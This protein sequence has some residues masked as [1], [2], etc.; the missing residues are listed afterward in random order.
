M[1]SGL[2]VIERITSL[3]RLLETVQ[4]EAVETLTAALHQGV[5]EAEAADPNDLWNV[6]ARFWPTSGRF[7][8]SDREGHPSL[9]QECFLSELII[10]GDRGGILRMKSLG[11]ADV[12]VLIPLV[13]Y[14]RA[15][16]ELSAH[17]LASALL[18]E[19]ERVVRLGLQAGDDARVLLLTHRERI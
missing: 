4:P 18:D 9:E 11:H 6:T 10:E 3:T 15:G 19:T 13:P 2:R 8:R 5:A 17:A 16:S 14:I 12:V 7:T 1:P